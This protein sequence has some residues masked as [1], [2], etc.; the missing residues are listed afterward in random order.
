MISTIPKASWSGVALI[1]FTAASI[2]IAIVIATRT[3]PETNAG[4]YR[5]PTRPRTRP[6]SPNLPL[7]PLPRKSIAAAFLL[8]SRSKNP[9]KK[10]LI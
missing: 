3:D 1:I 8:T 4:G 2:A 7:P 9:F 6:K 10:S 5:Q